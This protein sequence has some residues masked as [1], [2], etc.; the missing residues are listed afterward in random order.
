MRKASLPKDSKRYTELAFQEKAKW[1]RRRARMS[2][3]RKPQELE[4]LREMAKS[5]PKLIDQ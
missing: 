5:L 2:F 1:H 3:V 4:K